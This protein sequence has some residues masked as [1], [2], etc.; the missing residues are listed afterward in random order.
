MLERPSNRFKQRRT[1]KTRVVLKSANVSNLERLATQKGEHDPLA[2]II[3]ALALD[4]P[5][6]AACTGHVIV[7]VAAMVGD[8]LSRST[9][10]RTVLLLTTSN[11]SQM[12]TKNKLMVPR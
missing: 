4:H 11:K 3:A 8:S 12:G 9:T 1:T 5:A 2:Q 7:I 10:C 6:G